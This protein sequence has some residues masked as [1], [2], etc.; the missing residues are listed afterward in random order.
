MAIPFIATEISGV[1]TQTYASGAINRGFLDS[2]SG[3][4]SDRI[5]GIQPVENWSYINDGTGITAWGN[6]TFA[7][8]GT[9]G[10]TIS[11]DFGPGAAQVASGTHIHDDRY[12]TETEIKAGYY[13][14]SLGYGLSSNFNAFETDLGALSSNFQ[15][16]EADTNNPHQVEWSDVSTAA[17][18]DLDDNYYPSSVGAALSSNF[19]SHEATATIHFTSGAAKTYYDTLYEPAGTSGYQEISNGYASFTHSLG[20]KPKTI[21]ITPSGAVSFAYVASSNATNITVNTSTVNTVWIFW[22]AWK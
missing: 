17:I 5:V 16:H 13:P 1:A 20:Q 19:Q 4:L 11:V 15:A 6:D 7:V 14:S 8:S 18:T 9:G 3:N 22:N 12:F 2:V 10:L 21:Q